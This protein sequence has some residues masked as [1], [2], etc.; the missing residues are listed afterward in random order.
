M[1]LTETISL[2]NILQLNI[3][4]WID[5]LRSNYNNTCSGLN[6]QNGCQDKAE[7]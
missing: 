1:N 5:F 7:A 2:G 4:I 3:I 6:F